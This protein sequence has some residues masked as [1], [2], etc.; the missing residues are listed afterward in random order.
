[1]T[2]TP[3]QLLRVQELHLHRCR[4]PT[5]ACTTQQRKRRACSPSECHGNGSPTLS[6]AFPLTE[7]SQAI[8]AAEAPPWAGQATLANPTVPQ[9]STAERDPSTKRSRK[10][11]G[12]P[13]SSPP[14]GSAGS[15]SPEV[16]A[17]PLDPALAHELV[18]SPYAP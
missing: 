14:M 10:G 2:L 17:P 15:A 7:H 18:N 8:P 5:R 6:R 3:V 16:G 1:M 13:D 4:R 9:Q 12:A 11:P